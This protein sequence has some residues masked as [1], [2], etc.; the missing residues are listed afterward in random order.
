[1]IFFSFF[2]YKICLIEVLFFTRSFNI[3]I[4]MLSYDNV[5]TINILKKGL[6]CF[7][8]K[9]I[10]FCIYELYYNSL[11]NNSRIYFLHRLRNYKIC[12][13]LTNLV[14]TNLGHR[15]PMAKHMLYIL[16]TRLIT[17]KYI[18]LGLSLLI[19]M[20]FSSVHLK[21]ETFPIYNNSSNMGTSKSWN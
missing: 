18:L 2:I 15:T 20:L 10:N 21:F 16:Y 13:I 4:F 7:L 6:E 3:F 17:L 8:Q 11:R 9:I 1:M 14:Y 5:N 19:E 12:T